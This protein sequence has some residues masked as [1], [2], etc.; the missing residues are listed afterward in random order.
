[1]QCNFKIHIV[2]PKS[3]TCSVS[4]HEHEALY[5]AANSPYKLQL[6]SKLVKNFSFSKRQNALLIWEKKL[7][8][9][10]IL[11]SQKWFCPSSPGLQLKCIKKLQWSH[12]WATISWEKTLEQ[13]GKQKKTPQCIP[14]S[15]LSVERFSFFLCK[16]NDQVELLQYNEKKQLSVWDHE[17]INI[18][19]KAHYVLPLANVLLAT[20]D[21]DPAKISSPNEFFLGNILLHYYTQ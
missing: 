1:M 14:E 4:H 6:K 21:C 13:R 11:S 3:E 9:V 17:S 19:G 8:L 5:S 12:K 15:L 16:G 2:L 18:T 7:H 10:L 20:L